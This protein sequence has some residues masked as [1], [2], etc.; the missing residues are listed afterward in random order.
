MTG[1]DPGAGEYAP[2]DLIHRL[3]R[4]RAVDRITWLEERCRNRRVVHVGFADAGFADQRQR[5]GRWLH[6]RLADMAAELVGVDFDAARVAGAV[7]AGY[8]AYAADC[9]DPVAV[10]GL[11]IEPADVVLA[12]EVIEHVDRP[13]PFLDA[14]RHLSR[15]NGRLVITTPNAHGLAYAAIPLLR[16]IEITHPDH[17]LAFTYR[18]LTELVHRHGWRIVETITYT[19]AYTGRGNRSRL[20][21][22]ALR[23]LLCIERVLSRCGRPF[24][25]SGLIVVAEPA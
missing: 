24:A 12:G 20:E 21:A 17:I 19:P 11:G 8:E 23:A 5:D 3:P 16:G 18:T 22:A 10:A 2:D 25:A 7:D 14:L 6:A 13:G 15:A 9:A 4:A 1:A